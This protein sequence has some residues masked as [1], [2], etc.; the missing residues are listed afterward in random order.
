MEPGDLPFFQPPG[1]QPRLGL[2]REVDI[3]PS[4]AVTFAPNSDAVELG[5]AP[6]FVAGALLGASLGVQVV[7]L[8]GVAAA[9][10]RLL[11]IIMFV[12]AWRFVRDAR[13]GPVSSAP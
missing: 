3:E 4:P 6:W 7:H 10:R 2:P 8:D 11:A 13:R 5:V 1:G 9:G 12:T